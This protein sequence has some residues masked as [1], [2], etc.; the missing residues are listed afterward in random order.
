[1]AGADPSFSEVHIL[2]TLFTLH[3][4]TMGRKRLVKV[5]GVGE[6]SVRTIIKRLTSDG[7]ITSSKSGH[8]LTSAGQ[9]NVESTLARVS[10]PQELDLGD[11]VA[12][13]QS[14]VVV[15]QAADRVGDGVALRDIALKAGADGAVVL[16]NSGQLCFP[17]SGLSL[18]EYPTAMHAFE[19]IGSNP[20]DA[21]VVGF[22]AS[23]SKA[24]DG[25]LAVALKIRG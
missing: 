8:S 2:R 24:Q 16:V 11:F 4:G 19:A 25:A 5:L 13:T 20:G 6:G 1:M 14:V 22:A 10:K 18:K 12:G 15:R 17:G 9:A 23:V 7:L 21:I 3:S